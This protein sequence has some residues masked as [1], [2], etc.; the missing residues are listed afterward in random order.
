MENFSTSS[1]SDFSESDFICDPFFQEWI[2]HPNPE[3]DRFWNDFILAHPHKE[4]TFS[5]A[6]LVLK[7]LSFKN[8]IPDEARIRFLFEEHLRQIQMPGK[9]KLVRFNSSVVKRI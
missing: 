5:K 8:D 1:Y 6:T 3:T 7:N 2:M 9:G 4:G